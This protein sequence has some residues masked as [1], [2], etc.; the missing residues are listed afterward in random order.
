MNPNLP[1]PP[2]TLC[3]L[4]LSALGDATHVV[5]VVRTLQRHWPETRITW[6]IGRLE[7]ALLEGLEGVEFVVVDKREGFTAWRRLRRTLAGRR[8]DV[9]FHMQVSLRASLY[10]TAVRARLRVGFDRARARDLQWLFTNRRIAAV[11]RQHVLEGFFEFPAALGLGAR[12]LRWEIP[13]PAAD[14]AWAAER[15]TGP[16][17]V[18]SPCS[19]FAYRNWLPERYAAVA[20]HAVERHGLRV[21]LSGGPTAIER[22]YA[23]IIRARAGVPVTDLVGRT[24]L[25]QVLALLERAIALVAPDSGPAHM[26]TAVGT[27]VIGLYACTNPDRARPYL[28]ARWVVNRYPEALRAEYGQTVEEAPWGRRVRAP[29]AM[30]R[31]T[32]ADVTAM[33]DRLMHDTSGSDGT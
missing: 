24:S 8:F 7:H 25:K 4:R 33:L 1:H 5:P 26:A 18:I 31:I 11:P 29:H 9:L 6:I 22:R 28:S 14:R 17:L 30:E 13:V 19:S 23:Q 27:P 10:S 15:V 21:I 16:T 2:R 12:E 20:R 3:I 32:V